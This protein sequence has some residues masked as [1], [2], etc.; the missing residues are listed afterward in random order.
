MCCRWH[1]SSSLPSQMGYFRHLPEFPL[2]TA[3]PWQVVRVEGCCHLPESGLPIC[4]PCVAVTGIRHGIIW[5]TPEENAEPQSI[6]RKRLKTSPSSPASLV[7]V[8]GW[9][10]HPCP[11][12]CRAPAWS[13]IFLC[14][15]VRREGR[16]RSSELCTEWWWSDIVMTTRADFSVA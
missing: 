2:A 6:K 8:R 15:N 10:Q 5:E 9:L 1:T 12:R 4:M 14:R 11:P 16:L 3:I 13:H 7:R